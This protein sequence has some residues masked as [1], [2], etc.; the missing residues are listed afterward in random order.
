MYH[1][2]A[3]LSLC[4]LLVTLI[5]SS[6]FF[7]PRYGEEER[8]A[9]REGAEVSRKQEIANATVRGIVYVK[10]PRTGI[11]FACIRQSDYGGPVL[12]TVP[13]EKIP[14]ELLIIAEVPE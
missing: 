6:Y 9:V 2:K 12:A 4:A 11:C 7:L 13:E 10:D 14:P 1:P 3:V 8:R 5:V